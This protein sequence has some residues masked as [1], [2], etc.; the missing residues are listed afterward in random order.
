MIS[1]YILDVAASAVWAERGQVPAEGRGGETHLTHGGE[2]RHG[3]T[4]SGIQATD[5]L[6]CEDFCHCLRYMFLF[7]Y[8]VYWYYAIVWHW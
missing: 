4:T 1:Q 5:T 7:Y 3:E 6:T 2:G 8:V